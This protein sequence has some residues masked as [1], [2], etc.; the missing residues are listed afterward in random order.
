VEELAR[1][2]S[3]AL[4]DAARRQ[5]KI[6]LI[7]D[8]LGKVV[9]AIEGSRE[10]TLF[11]FS[12]LFSTREKKEGLERMLSGADEIFLNF[13]KVLIDN[14]RMP[15]IFRIR[16]QYEDLWRE[17]NKLLPVEVTSAVELDDEVARQ[18]QQRVEQQTVRR[19]ELT[20]RVDDGILGGL[21]VRVSNMILDASIRNQLERLRRQV[22]KAT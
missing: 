18:I 21:V 3:E 19:V 14:H 5:G 2:Y 6:D 16:K 1:V 15:V 17:E 12:P 4:F 9:E 13:L 7:R 11:F 20:R 10:L 22:A 8:Q